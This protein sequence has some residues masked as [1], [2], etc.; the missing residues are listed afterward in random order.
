MRDPD[1]IPKTLELLDEVDLTRLHTQD[2]P[3]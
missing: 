2:L 1:R 3:G